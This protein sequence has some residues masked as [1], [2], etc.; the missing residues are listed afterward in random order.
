V[1]SSGGDSGQGILDTLKAAGAAVTGGIA[2]HPLPAALIGAG[3][4][5]M[6]VEN[7]INAGSRAG[8]DDEDG[9]LARA[10]RRYHEASE[11]AAETVGSALEAAK[12]SLAGGA[13]AVRGGVAGA[14]GRAAGLAQQGAAA[15]GSKLKEGASAVGEGARHGYRASRKAVGNVW[16][17]HPLASGLAV[18]AAGITL[19]M[20]L[21]ATRR[22][23]NVIGRQ[24]NA[25]ARRAKE[26]GSNVAH[27]GRRI[28]SSVG[29]AV[30]REVAS[31]GRTGASSRRG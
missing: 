12:E 28:V 7:R 25:L 18:L 24:S 5:W 10:R 31:A 1:S 13:T 3:L 4:A 6:V 21:P 23:L 15:V 22:E 29:N 30:K 16:D 8:A 27:R 17:E 26:A 14:A 20:L 19:G 11:E 2:G 9:I